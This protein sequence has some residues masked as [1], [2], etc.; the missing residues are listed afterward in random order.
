MCFVRH[1]TA[2]EEMPCYDAGIMGLRLGKDLSLRH[3]FKRDSRGETVWDDC[4]C[5]LGTVAGMYVLYVC[6]YVC[7]YSMY[8]RTLS[9]VGCCLRYY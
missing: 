3:D 4:T 8:V 9:T 1:L 5:A 7:M 6:M 2:W